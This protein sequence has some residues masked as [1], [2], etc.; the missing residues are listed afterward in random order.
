[1]HQIYFSV[2]ILTLPYF[3]LFFLSTAATATAPAPADAAAAAVTA[4]ARAAAATTCYSCCCCYYDD[5]DHHHHHD[6]YYYYCYY[7]E[8]DDHHP[9]TSS[10]SSDITTTGKKST[11]MNI[12]MN[13]LNTCFSF[14][15]GKCERPLSLRNAR[16]LSSLELPLL[17][18]AEGFITIT[19]RVP[20]VQPEYK[21]YFAWSREVR[22]RSAQAAC[23]EGFQRVECRLW[24]R[25]G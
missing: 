6:Y 20:S 1:M 23:R 2:C 12:G 13:L 4:A 17:D 15:A 18:M 21:S 5:D 10:A 11:C 22:V 16:V 19:L 3:L 14:H 7:C 24:S 25:S 9:T 8:A